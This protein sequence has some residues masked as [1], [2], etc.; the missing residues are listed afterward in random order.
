MTTGFV[1][2][3]KGKI[4]AHILYVGPGGL[5]ASGPIARNAA[6]GLVAAG[7]NR[8][9]AL[10]L[11]ADINQ[12]ATAAAGTGVALP[13]AT[14]PGQTVDVYNDGANAIK[15]YAQG[16]DTIDGTAGA[17]GVTLTN[18][19]R[20]RYTVMS[21]SNGVATWESAQFGVASA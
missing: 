21:I 7:T 17:T 14:A 9:T 12:V 10:A 11:A 16:T 13:T 20:C 15:V 2:R 19:K 4:R 5:I 18:A 8:A 1:Q 3:F 6:A